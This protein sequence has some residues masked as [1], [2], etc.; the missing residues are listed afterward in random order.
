[1][2]RVAITDYWKI[3][4]VRDVMDNVV[5][6]QKDAEAISRIGSGVYRR[7]DRSERG[8]GGQPARREGAVG[9]G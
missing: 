3:S 5:L 4:T 9:D 2:S 8:K 1:M 6:D 7:V